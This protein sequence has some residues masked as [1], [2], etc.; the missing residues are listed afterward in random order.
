MKKSPGM[1]GRSERRTEDE[2]EVGED[3]S[4]VGEARD[5]VQRALVLRQRDARQDELDDVAEGGV[6]EAADDLARA[7]RQVLRHLAQDERQG[8]DPE[9]VLRTPEVASDMLTF[10][11]FLR[12]RTRRLAW[13]R[14]REGAHEAED[15]RGAPLLVVC[16]VAQ[17]REH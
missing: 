1:K 10:S 14:G 16:D 5:V 8:D 9:K 17:R 11:S 12:L 3:G 2:Q 15:E 13:Q 6:D 7:Q 4:Q